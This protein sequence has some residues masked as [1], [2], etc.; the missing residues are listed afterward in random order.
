MV[1]RTFFFILLLSIVACGYH[2]VKTPGLSVYVA[3][4][5][6]RSDHAKLGILLERAIENRLL[7][8]G[9]RTVNSP[10]GATVWIKAQLDS[11]NR[12]T[13]QSGIDNRVT[14]RR[15]TISLKALFQGEKGERTKRKDFP[16]LTRYPTQSVFY[17]NDSG[18]EE[19][20][21]A[22]QMALQVVVWLTNP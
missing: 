7:Q 18:R 17:Y 10:D 16:L 9:F 21:L 22:R 11:G 1:K 8:R 13:L 15:E 3:P 12:R 14:T 19:R 5:D 2:T 4:V 6:N 20:E